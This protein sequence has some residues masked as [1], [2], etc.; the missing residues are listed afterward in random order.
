MIAFDAAIAAIQA[1]PDARLIAIDGLPVS[2]KSTLATRLQTELGATIV[3]LDDFV[4]LEQEWRGRTAPAFPFPF[5]RYDEFLGVVTSLSRGEGARYRPYDWDTG[6]LSVPREIVPDGVLVVDGVSALH[7]QLA[8][9]YDLRL[10]VESDAATVLDASLA[11]GVGGWEQEWR[12]LFLPSVA[13]YLETKPVGRADI[14]V[15]GRGAGM[16]P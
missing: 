13:L 16:P 4:R 6:Q 10:W 2:G 15:A 3:S 5:I 1:R 14:L 11:R 8:P 9:L 7:P 12:A